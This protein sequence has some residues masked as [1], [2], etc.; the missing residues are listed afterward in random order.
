MNKIKEEIITMLIDHSRIIYSVISDMG[1]YY[2]MWVEDF[3]SNKKSLEKKQNKM[4]L[5]EEDADDI[6]IQMIKNYS[7]AEAQGIGDYIALILRMDNLI[8][9]PLEFVDN[10]TKI[11]L[12][13]KNGEIKKR[14]KKLINKIIEM[15]DVLK[16][17]IKSLRDNPD[18]V[19]NNTTSIHEIENGV[20]TIFREFLDYIYTDKDIDIRV[21]LR[22]RDSIMLL[23]KFAD[24]IHDIA[25]LIRVLL[26]Q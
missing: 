5:L 19:F 9:Y 11:N 22:L 23:E 13:D 17:I 4:Q 6:K 8:N 10:L 20:D 14:Y 26:Y 18:A 15:V 24:S 7:E 25:D 21:L 2:S 3:E 1:T 16:T 12:D